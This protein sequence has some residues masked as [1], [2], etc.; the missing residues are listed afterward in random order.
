M[1][2]RIITIMGAAAL[3]LLLSACGKSEIPVYRLEDSAVCFPQITNSFS[4]RGMTEAERKLTVP[5][6]L[7][8]PAADFVRPLSLR[9]EE[10][11]AT[12]GTDFTV[13]SAEVAAGALSG[14]IVLN[15][16]K[17]SEQTP[18]RSIS[19][20]LLPND[21]FREG[22]PAYLKADITWSEAYERPQE[23]AWRYW[24]LYL[25]NTYSRN[26][27]KLLVEIYGD[28]IERY[29]CGRQYERDYGF[30]YKLPTWWMAANYEIREIVRK[31]DLENPGNPYRHSED[32]E[33]FRGYTLPVGGG[34][35][36]EP[37]QTPPTILE[38]INSL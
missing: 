31:H 37:G 25:S 35:A 36:L 20:T 2:Q 6:T 23:G 14:S 7:I 34:V 26:W 17:L 9:I 22:Y 19:V 1:K 8:G 32:F 3:A 18:S 15:V 30:I 11:S 16:K 28:D 10:V 27:H 24:Y 4:L 38:T 13:E 5:V 33:S 29:T 12:E 21:H